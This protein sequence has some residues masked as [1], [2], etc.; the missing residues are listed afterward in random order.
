MS[1]QI[2]TAMG[3]NEQQ[4]CAIKASFL[5]EGKWSVARH[6]EVFPEAKESTPSVDM[7]VSMASKNPPSAC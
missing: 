5:E 6:R 3:I 1:G 4:F 7:L 2:M